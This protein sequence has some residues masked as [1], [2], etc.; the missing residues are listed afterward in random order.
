VSEKTSAGRGPSGAVVPE[1]GRRTDDQARPNKR[2][3]DPSGPDTPLSASNLESI[4]ST[5]ELCWR[6]SRPPD[7]AAENR[8]LVALAQEMA[9][10]PSG[11]LQKLVEIALTLCRAHSAGL[12][13]LE[14]GDQ[15]RKFHWRAIAGQWASQPGRRYA[16]GLWSMRHSPGPERRS[17]VFAP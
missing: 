13:L 6:P 3:P 7:H 12:S 17:G 15:Q 10:S 11:I 9:T 8:A 5:A 1:F 16:T 4:T 14:K 2:H